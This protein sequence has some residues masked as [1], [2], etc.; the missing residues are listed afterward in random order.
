MST[1]AQRGV[2][3]A[4]TALVEPAATRAPSCEHCGV[5]VSDF[6]PNLKTVLCDRCERRLRAIKLIHTVVAFILTFGV[7]WFVMPALVEQAVQRPHTSSNPLLIPL[8]LFCFVAGT[9]LQMFFHENAHALTARAVGYTV[10]RVKFGTGKVLYRRRVGDTTIELRRSLFGGQTGWRPG[11]GRMSRI[12][13]VAVTLA[14]PLASL[15][16]AAGQEAT[17]GI[18]P[19]DRSNETAEPDMGGRAGE[20][21]ED[22]KC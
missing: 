2:P 15:A 17:T 8:V 7:V 19:V 11:L 9:A 10:T 4:N 21:S 5:E 18:E 6:D 1:I 20:N 14:G 12:R 16:F 13:R 3:A 22:L